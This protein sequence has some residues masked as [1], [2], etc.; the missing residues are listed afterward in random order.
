MWGRR[1]LSASPPAVPA[2][3]QEQRAARRLLEEQ[4]S[5]RQEAEW[6]AANPL[7]RFKVTYLEGELPRIIEAHAV[8]VDD[9]KGVGRVKFWRKSFNPGYMK[10]YRSELIFFA[11]SAN[12]RSVELLE[13]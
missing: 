13:D 2:E 9:D 5:A 11:F 8:T 1:L 6:V 4:E 10:W 12:V 7:L 3:T